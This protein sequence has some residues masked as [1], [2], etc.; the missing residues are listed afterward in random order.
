LIVSR[1]YSTWREGAIALFQGVNA[2]SQDR[3]GKDQQDRERTRRTG[4]DQQDRPRE[5]RKGQDSLFQEVQV[6]I[7]IF[8]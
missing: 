2:Y 8:E 3:T 1:C 7:K 5:D 6:V 4:E